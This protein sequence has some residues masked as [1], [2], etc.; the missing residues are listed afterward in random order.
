MVLILLR[1]TLIR[2]DLDLEVLLSVI[3]GDSIARQTLYLMP[4]LHNSRLLSC[5]STSSSLRLMMKE[6][7]AGFSVFYSWVIGC[8]SISLLFVFFNHPTSRLGSHSHP[9]RLQ[10]SSYRLRKL[11][12]W[13]R[14]SS[15]HLPTLQLPKPME[16]RKDDPFLSLISTLFIIEAKIKAKK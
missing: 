8:V 10:H 1:K 3:P 5:G 14:N 7:D 13:R 2:K 16:G 11:S 4:C 9:E 15:S 6:L 12:R